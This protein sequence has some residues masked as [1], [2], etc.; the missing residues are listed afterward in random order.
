MANTAVESA[1]KNNSKTG[2]NIPAQ[3]SGASI[4]LTNEQFSNNTNQEPN[5][6]QV[7][8]NSIVTTITEQKKGKN[9]SISFEVENV[10]NEKDAD[11]KIEDLL[12][13]SSIT[14]ALNNKTIIDKL[15]RNGI[16]ITKISGLKFKGAIISPILSNKVT[17]ENCTFTNDST[18]HFNGENLICTG[19]TFENNVAIH[20]TNKDA[21]VIIENSTLPKKIEANVKGDERTEKRLNALKFIGK[22]KKLS[23]ENNNNGEGGLIDSERAIISEKINFIGISDDD[24]LSLY[25]GSIIRKHQLTQEIINALI[26]SKQK[27]DSSLKEADA[28]QKCLIQDRE[29]QVRIITNLD[30][31]CE[32]KEQIKEESANVFKKKGSD[33][34]KVIRDNYDEVDTYV[35]SKAISK[36]FTIEKVKETFDNFISEINKKKEEQGEKKKLVFDKNYEKICT[37]FK[38]KSAEIE[39]SKEQVVEESKN[40]EKAENKTKTSEAPKEQKQGENSD[41]TSNSSNNETKPIETGEVKEQQASHDSVEASKETTKKKSSIF[42]KTWSGIKGVASLFTRSHKNNESESK[43]TNDSS[44]TAENSAEPPISSN[45]ITPKDDNLLFGTPNGTNNPTSSN[46]NPP[47]DEKTKAKSKKQN[48]KD[49]SPKV[50]VKLPSIDDDFE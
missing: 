45:I 5:N 17:L 33:E 2:G 38:R 36:G 34:T 11:K 20:S 42:G 39:K 29:Q 48:D 15:K 24:V 30:D 46:T 7:I 26:K 27:N 19:C 28:L 40:E 32:R 21:K 47:K 44:S 6:S 50:E 43:T 14:D 23:L 49:A 12:K 8:N 10:A 16:K 3:D 1:P 25:G 4:D 13:S 9:F 37:Y 35:V 18:F 22:F 41:P 31:S